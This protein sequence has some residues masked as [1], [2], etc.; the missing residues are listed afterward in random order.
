MNICGINASSCFAGQE[1]FVL[2]ILGGAEKYA[3]AE[4]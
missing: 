2:M 3:N 4:Y 1:K